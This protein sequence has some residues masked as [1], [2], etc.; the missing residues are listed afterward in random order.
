M[1]TSVELWKTENSEAWRTY[2]TLKCNDRAIDIWTDTA[3][4]VKVTKTFEIGGI[5]ENSIRIESSGGVFMVYEFDYGYNHFCFMFLRN[6]E[7]GCCGWIDIGDWEAFF[8]TRSNAIGLSRQTIPSQ[9][10]LHDNN[11]RI[12]EEL[13][14]WLLAEGG[15][16]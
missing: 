1:T 8:D 15:N 16:E 12:L 14:Y 5:Q 9:L 11:Y 13:L 10:T 7:R 4:T 3:N 6:I 2:Y